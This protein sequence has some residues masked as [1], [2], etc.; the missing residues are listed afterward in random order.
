MFYIIKQTFCS[1]GVISAQVL[2]LLPCNENISK[3]PFHLINLSMA[4]YTLFIIIFQLLLN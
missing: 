4:Y 2:L 1:S 3:T